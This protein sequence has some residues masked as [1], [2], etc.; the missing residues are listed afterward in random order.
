MTASVPIGAIPHD[1]SHC[2]AEFEQAV[3]AL[4]SELEASLT[5]SQKAL[6]GRDL[7]AITTCTEEQTRLVRALAV[8]LQASLTRREAPGV[9]VAPF[10]P[11][12][13]SSLVLIAAEKRVWQLA[14]VQAAL[15]KRA[16]RSLR[17]L[18]RLLAGPQ[19]SYGPAPERTVNV[20]H[21]ARS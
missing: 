21:V 14:R 17:I 6:L 11:K 1:T 7:K 13:K 9:A 18:A 10:R 8:L 16:Q 2:D 19:T 3:L 12:V 5:V 4:L 20:V 15:L